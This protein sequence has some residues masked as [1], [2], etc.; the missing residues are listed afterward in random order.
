MRSDRL[1]RNEPHPTD[2]AIIGTDIKTSP[3]EWTRTDLPVGWAQETCQRLVVRLGRRSGLAVVV[4]P[5]SP[6]TSRR[7]LRDRLP[8][9]VTSAGPADHQPGRHPADALRHI[10]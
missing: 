8:V 3:R 1:T 6:L 5:V 4:C 9:S 7:R 2:Q 10:D